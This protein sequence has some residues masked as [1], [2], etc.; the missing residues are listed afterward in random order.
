MHTGTR[1]TKQLFGIDCNVHVHMQNIPHELKHPEFIVAP[2]RDPR[3]AWASWFHRGR[4]AVEFRCSW[5][6]LECFSHIY[7]LHWFPVDHQ[8]RY[9]WKRLIERKLGLGD[10]PTDWHP[11][12]RDNDDFREPP[13]ID[14]A[15]IYR[16]ECVRQFYGNN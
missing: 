2:I 16:L 14:L 5:Y 12:G 1:F 10:L 7:F 15:D 8:A 11:V 9:G 13:D 4:S 6:L 3:S